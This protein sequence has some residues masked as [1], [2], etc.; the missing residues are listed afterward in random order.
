VAG[1]AVVLRA[2]AAL[3]LN[4]VL[5][6]LAT[7][8]AK[9]GA[10]SVPEGCVEVRWRVDGTAGGPRLVL[11]WTETGGPEVYPPERRGFGCQLIERSVAHE[12]DGMVQLEF[13]PQGVRCRVEIPLQPGPGS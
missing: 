6:E 12:L 3:N 5:H 7:N 8:A 11:G 2:E 10:L 9:H 4:M 13:L 1:E